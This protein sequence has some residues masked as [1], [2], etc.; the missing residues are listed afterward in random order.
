M[1]FTVTS[2]VDHKNIE[3]KGVLQVFEIPD[4]EM[5]ILCAL[6]C[7]GYLLRSHGRC[8]AR[9]VS[10]LISGRKRYSELKIERNDLECRSNQQLIS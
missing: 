2:L 8:T 9:L 5:D 6:D 1:R 3:I 4:D 10:K 7:Y